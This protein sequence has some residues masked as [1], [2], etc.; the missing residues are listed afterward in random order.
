[1]FFIN[2]NL[3]LFLHSVNIATGTAPN[4]GSRSCHNRNPAGNNSHNG[5]YTPDSMVQQQHKNSHQGWLNPSRPVE[6][7]F[8][9]PMLSSQGFSQV[10]SC[11]IMGF[12]EVAIHSMF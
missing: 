7:G 3:F 1:M 11:L 12:F 5:R 6:T 10:S 9:N 8:H 4:F 2:E